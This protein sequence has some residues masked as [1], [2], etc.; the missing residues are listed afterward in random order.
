MSET[1]GFGKEK[2]YCA[3]WYPTIFHHSSLIPSKRINA[4]KGVDISDNA[5]PGVRL[6]LDVN[7]D[8]DG[9]LDFEMYKSVD[10]SQRVVIKKI[11][12]DLEKQSN[13]GFAVYSCCDANVDLDDEL[14]KNVF[15]HHAKSLRHDHEVNADSDSGLSAMV[16]K[17]GVSFDPHVIFEQD[18]CVIQY[19]L[20]Q[21]EELFGSRYA[22][23]ISDRNLFYDKLIKTFRIFRQNDFLR[24][25]DELDEDS[26]LEFD[27][28]IHECYFS[29]KFMTGESK[30]LC[31]Y[32]PKIHSKCY[33][34]RL[35]R[36]IQKEQPLFYEKFVCQLKDLCENAMMEYTYCQTLL[37]SKYNTEIRH[38]I[39]FS[40]EE[41]SALAD[42]VKDNSI[43]KRRDSSRKTANNIQN[44]MR[45]IRCIM[46]KC[47]N[48]AD[49]HIRNVLSMADRTS[50]WAIWLSV[51][52]GVITVLS[53]I[54]A[55][56]SQ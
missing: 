46:F 6:Y 42:G 39:R 44:S 54:V 52:F 23:M 34:R 49:E 11:H 43:L 37:N 24:K 17:K 51:F 55:L 26:A 25:F 7:E 50:R 1:T 47:S 29:A 45:Y 48:Y 13:N 5:E 14:F 9:N 36:K 31:N 12:L 53:L 19:Y 27:K 56:M 20:K 21:Y 3:F 22:K 30:R 10:G 40:S 15:F 16:I 35:G 41:V 2:Q 33:Y 38:D 32:M 8:E 18:N 4:I 28:V